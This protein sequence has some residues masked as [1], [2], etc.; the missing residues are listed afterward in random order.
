[1]GCEKKYNVLCSSRGHKIQA[2]I[3][4]RH[5][6]P[7]QEDIVHGGTIDLNEE[8]TYRPIGKRPCRRL[9]VMCFLRQWTV[10]LVQKFYGARTS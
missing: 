8:S 4:V 9:E 6:S 2:C 5:L 10:D 7:S 1:V 3:V